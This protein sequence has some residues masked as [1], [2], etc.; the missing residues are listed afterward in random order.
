MRAKHAAQIRKGIRFARNFNWFVEPSHR[1]MIYQHFLKTASYLE[2]KA[3]ERT[4]VRD[5]TK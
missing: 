4:R 1:R 5:F 2:Y 3:F